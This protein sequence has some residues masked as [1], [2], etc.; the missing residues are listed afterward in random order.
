MRCC[1][2]LF[3]PAEHRSGQ[4]FSGSRLS[5]SGIAAG[6]ESSLIAEGQLE[7]CLCMESRRQECCAVNSEEE[8]ID[9]E[10]DTAWQ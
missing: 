10:E 8:E 4:Y 2:L 9:G 6:K 3:I 5:G 7:A 1:S